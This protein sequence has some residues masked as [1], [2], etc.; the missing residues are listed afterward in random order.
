MPIKRWRRRSRGEKSARRLSAA[1]PELV[2]W[3]MGA[4]PRL[5][6]QIELKAAAGRWQVWVDAADGSILLAYDDRQRIAAPSSSGANA[7]VPAPS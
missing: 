1:E 2:V 3:A 6:Y 5:A 4:A 7:N